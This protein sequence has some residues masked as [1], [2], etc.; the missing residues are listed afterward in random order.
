MA[1]A[2]GPAHLPGVPAQEVGGGRDRH[3][4][5]HARQDDHGPQTAHCRAHGSA[6]GIPAASQGTYSLMAQARHDRGTALAVDGKA[7]HILCLVLF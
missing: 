1:H 7:F 5:D 3:L 6:G 2:Q 4:V